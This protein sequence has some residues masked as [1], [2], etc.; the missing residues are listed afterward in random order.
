MSSSSFEKSTTNKTNIK[1]NINDTNNKIRFFSRNANV[2]KE[3]VEKGTKEW[4]SVPSA[5]RRAFLRLGLISERENTANEIRDSRLEATEKRLGDVEKRCQI[6]LNGVECER[7]EN[8]RLMERLSSLEKEHATFR[9]ECETIVSGLEKHVLNV[10]TE[11][12]QMKATVAKS[13]Q[14]EAIVKANEIAL[15]AVASSV[16]DAVAV[17]R[18][19]KDEA[20]RCVKMMERGFDV[21]EIRRWS[22]IRR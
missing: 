8:A 20:K 5:V 18:V 2:I 15:N 9:N 4:S 6:L 21:N 11:T 12:S 7:E 16:D 19:A 13:A 17:S 3:D 14:M 22:E 1:E 10:T